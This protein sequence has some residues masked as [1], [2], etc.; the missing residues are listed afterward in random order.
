MNHKKDLAIQR[1]F[2]DKKKSQCVGSQVRTHFFVFKRKTSLT[3][4]F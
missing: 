3:K 4:E 1:A 2:C